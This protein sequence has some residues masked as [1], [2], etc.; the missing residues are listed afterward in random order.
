MYCTFSETTVALTVFGS[1]LNHRSYPQ[2]KTGYPFFGP[3]CMAGDCAAYNVEGRLLTLVPLATAQQI[4]NRAHNNMY[5]LS[6]YSAF[7]IAEKLAY[8]NGIGGVQTPSFNCIF[9]F[10]IIVCMSRKS[11]H[12]NEISAHLLL[13]KS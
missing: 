4:S 3:P 13:I 6:Y 11:P 5:Q 7:R 8:R 1:V 10:F 2:N 9:R 12:S